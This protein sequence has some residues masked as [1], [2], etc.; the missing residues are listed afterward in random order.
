[1]QEN[2][3]TPD[4]NQVTKK[5]KVVAW[6][7]M[8]AG[9]EFAFLIAVPLIAGV[10]AGK[11]LDNKYNQHFFVIIGIFAGIAISSISIWKRINDYKNL[12]K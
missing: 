10:F 2:L 6:L 5:K 1:M 11:W 9:T 4:K 3:P 8:E 12:L 7:M